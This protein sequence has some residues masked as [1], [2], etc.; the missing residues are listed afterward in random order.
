MISFAQ[1]DPYFLSESEKRS[2]EKSD[3]DHKKKPS[4]VFM[5][6]PKKCAGKSDDEEQRGA[7]TTG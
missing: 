4:A 2:T 1:S 7:H 5:L 3:R 6:N